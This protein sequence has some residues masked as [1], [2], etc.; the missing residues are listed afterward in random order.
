VPGACALADLLL[1]CMTELRALRQPLAYS[2]KDAAEAVGI[3]AS[4]L[5]QLIARGD[6]HPRWVKSK[7]IIPATELIAWL[8]SLPYDRP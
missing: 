7:R 3:S 4:L 5:E 2:V 6:L 8:E 1:C